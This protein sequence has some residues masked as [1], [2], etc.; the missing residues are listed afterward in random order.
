VWLNCL[1][2][3]TKFL[4]TYF[5]ST[6][7]PSGR[8]KRKWKEVVEEDMK[9]WK[10]NKEDALVRSKLRRLISSIERMVRTVGVDVSDNFLVL[11]H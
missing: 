7:R 3:V 2:D 10:I 6:S 11:V 9:S 4:A 5:W 1:H 8:P